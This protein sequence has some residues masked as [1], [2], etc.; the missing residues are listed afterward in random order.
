M[1]RG[2]Q[3]DGARILRGTEFR[4]AG[5]IASLRTVVLTPELTFE[6]EKATVSTVSDAQETLS[7][8]AVLRLFTKKT[9]QREPLAGFERQTLI[10]GLRRDGATSDGGCGCVQRSSVRD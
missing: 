2:L 9:K 10:A 6:G 8:D 7:E 5:S 4:A 1:V 3:T